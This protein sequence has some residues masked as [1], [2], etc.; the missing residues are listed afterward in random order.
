MGDYCLTTGATGACYSTSNSAD[1]P[2]LEMAGVLSTDGAV[3]RDGSVVVVGDGSGVVSPG[4]DGSTTSVGPSSEGGGSDVSTV[5]ACVSAQTQFGNTAQ[6]DSNPGFTSGVGVQAGDDLLIFSSYSTPGTDAGTSGEG[7]ASS[8]AGSVNV[9]Y[10]QAFDAST[11]SSLG[12]A[13]PL[14]GVPSGSGFVLES[15]AVAPTGQIAIAFNYGGAYT[16]EAGSGSQAAL[17][18]AFL[19]PS[20]DAGSVGVSL[21]RI[22]ELENGTIT[23]QPHIIWSAAAGAFIFSWEYLDSGA[24]FIGTK[25]FLPSGQGAG[26]ADPVPTDTS[27]DNVH[28]YYYGAEQGSIAAGP[29]FR[30]MAFESDSTLSPTLTILDLN[31]NAVGGPVRIATVNDSL[32]WQTVAAVADGLVYLYSNANAVSELFVPISG[33][34]GAALSDA[35]DAGF[36]GFTFTGVG[37]FDVHAISDD[38]SGPGG[39]GA[40]MLYPDG[41]SFSYVNADGTTHVGPSSVIAHTYAAGDVFNIS[42]FRGS[43]AVSLYSTAT[44]STQMAA[45]GCR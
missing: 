17:Y 37:A 45:S 39:V 9:V 27:A 6:G 13:Q 21:Q 29:T 12:P 41:L 1:E 16:F 40:A 25:N 4:P 15:A 10:V 28:N 33:D 30:G 7:G 43:F 22:V 42:N 26:G 2:D 23:G 24:W 8:D 38:V 5:N 44:Q 18:A 14:F 11:A 3:I 36:S 31:G 35:S 32:G 20:A 34:A 19:G